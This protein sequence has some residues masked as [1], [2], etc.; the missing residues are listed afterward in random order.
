MSHYH[1][2]GIGGVGMSALASILLKDGQQVSGCDLAPSPLAYRLE[3]D[4]ATILRGHDAEHL[5]D[6]DTLVVTTAILPDHPEIV[7]AREKGVRVI[8][9]IELLGEILAKGTSLGVTGTHGKTTTSSMLA[10]IF[11]AAGT[12]PTILLGGEVADLGGNARYGSGKFRIAEID[13]SDPLFQHLKLDVAV[14]TNLEADHVSTPGEDRPNYHA[15]Y[16]A[17]QKAARTFA[18][19]ARALVYN[20]EWPLLCSLTEGLSRTGFGIERGEARAVNLELF[21][22]GS[23]F[24][25]SWHD[26]ILGT[27]ELKVVGRHNVQNALAAS[28]AALLQ[29]IPFEAAQAALSKF[30]GAHRRFEKVGE[31][32]GAWVVDDYAHHPTE[33]RETLLAARNSGR[34]VRVVFQ[35]HRYLR[36][37]QLWP[38]F[39]EALKLADETIVLEVY[40]AG[41][42]A[43]QG[44]TGAKIAEKLLA[45]GSRARFAEPGEAVDYLEQTLKPDDLILTMGAGDVWRVGTQ[46]VKRYQDTLSRSAIPR[47]EPR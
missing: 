5:E 47:L 12:D 43:I 13:E 40:S 36:T 34:R 14:I 21:P 9:R 42:E 35:P 25:F 26:E 45:E 18:K 37:L 15:S 1:L 22:A 19:N 23:R 20:A 4:G 2:M 10:S 7:A 29:G 44:V 11:M 39:A 38:E 33:V 6:V 16:E 3:S 30:R 28:A 41:E 27:V 8:R 17:L 24:D 32:K 31:V 46:L